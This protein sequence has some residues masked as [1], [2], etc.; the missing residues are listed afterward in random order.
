MPAIEIIE[1]DNKFRTLRREVYNR[2]FW[3][4]AYIMNEFYADE[5]YE[6]LCDDYADDCFSDFIGWLIAQG[7]TIFKN[8]V[9]DI[10]TI[11]ELENT[12]D[13][14]WFGFDYIANDTYKKKTDNHIPDG[15]IENF[16]ITG[17]KWSKEGDDF[18]NRYPKLWAKFGTIS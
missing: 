13:G 7:E 15:N 3:A 17:K 6:Y 2:D 16:E 9:K 4:V 5:Y 11:S 14:D 8:A 10:E 18:K 12:G 1:F